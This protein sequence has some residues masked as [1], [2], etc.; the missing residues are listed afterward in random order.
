[1][2]LDFT[3]DQK[4]FY[5]ADGTNHKSLDLTARLTR[6]RRIVADRKVPSPGEFQNIHTLAVDSKGNLI[7][8]EITNKRL[9]KFVP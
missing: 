3:P 1:M 2:S 7:T 6:N 8:A 5:V 4:Y 9:Q